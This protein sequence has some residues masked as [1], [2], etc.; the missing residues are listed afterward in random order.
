MLNSADTS[1]TLHECLD[2]YLSSLPLPGRELT[3]ADVEK[4]QD[5]KLSLIQGGAASVPVLLDRF[6]DPDFRIKDIC[7]DLVLEIGNPAKDPLY[8]ELG[9]RGPIM[10]IWIAA[11]LQHIGEESAMVRLWPYLRDPVDYVRHLTALALAFQILDSPATPP[12]ELLAVLVDALGNEQTIEGT[13]FTIAGSALG[14]LTRLSGESFISPPR[15]IQFYNY[16]HFLYP[17]PLHPFPFAADYIT[18]AEV[19]ERWNIRRRIQAWVASRPHPK[20]PGNENLR[21]W[22]K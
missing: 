4:G 7:Y 11:M 19:E 13:H 1:R 2:T 15:K 17:P 6:S 14:C 3:S 20:S 12:E 22:E 8:G 5:S 18:K 21:E 10:D 9:M 16:E